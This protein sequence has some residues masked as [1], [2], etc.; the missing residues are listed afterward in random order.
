MHN[1][2]ISVVG[3]GYV[4]L[5]VAVSL[6]RHG[7]VVAFDINENRINELKK[8]EDHTGEV[9]SEK[10]KS[11][12][13]LITKDSADLK[14]ADFH[15]V[16][17]P[18]PITNAKRPDLSPVYAA[19]RTVGKQLKHGDIVVYE[20]TVYPGVTED[21]CVPILEKESGLKYPE[22]FKVGYSPERINPG[23]KKN[24]LETIVKIVAGTDEETCNIVAEV[25]GSI[26]EAGIHKAPS[27]QVAETAKVIENTQR[28]INIALMNELA[29]ICNR[30]DID[31]LSVLE[32]ASTKWNF[33][34]F[35][36]GLVGGHC[37]G[38][39]PYYLT[40]KAE[41][42]GHNPQ[43]ILS[44]RRINDGMG[45]F[46]AHETIKHLFKKGIGSKASITIIG[47]T[48]KE[49]CPDIRNTRVIDIVKELESFGMSVQVVDSMADADEAEKE[50]GIKIVKAENLAPADAVIF[51]VQHKEYVEKGWSLVTSLL[52]NKKG[53]VADIKGCLD[54]TQK[55]DDV[56]LWRL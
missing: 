5:P 20:S 38:V 40:H 14:K 54:M 29:L 17:V 37:I 31:T 10:L 30:L 22:D 26:I 4:G 2:K 49:D 51:A 47:F 48:F 42:A 3:L 44:G 24:R 1:R 25:Y 39:D 9:A 55:P 36:P 7:Q 18:T 35:K 8:G 11:A 13:L 15:I 16:T 28:D 46:V 32:A 21:E 45:E 6:S 19:S 56:E 34:N 50:Y 53:F 33:L 41:L 27:I 12:D 23:D 52:K 43:V